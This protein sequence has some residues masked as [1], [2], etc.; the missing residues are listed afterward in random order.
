MLE[1][2]C[3]EEVTA[4]KHHRCYHCAGWIVPGERYRRFCGKMDHIYTLRTHLDCDALADEYDVDCGLV[5]ERGYEGQ[6]PLMESFGDG[7]FADLCAA[8]RGR[9]PHVI[10]RLELVEQRGDIR[11]AEMCRARGFEPEEDAAIYG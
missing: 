5:A 7:D 10:T 3:H 1:E 2:I 11:Y 9:Y 4:R 6:P 8:Y